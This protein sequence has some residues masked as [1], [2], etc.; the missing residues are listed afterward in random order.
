MLGATR[1]NTIKYR[2]PIAQIVTDGESTFG[3]A[4]QPDDTIQKIDELSEKVNV[5]QAL[6]DDVQK[7]KTVAETTESDDQNEETADEKVAVTEEQEN[8]LPFGVYLCKGILLPRAKKP[9]V[10]GYYLK[11]NTSEQIQSLVFFD[12][13]EYTDTQKC[14]SG[15]MYSVNGVI[16]VFDGTT[17]KLLGL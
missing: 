7:V 16:Y 1:Y 14:Q 17:C 5:L 15:K 2:H 12:G 4:S 9:E 13:T 3:A 11:Q 8:Y 10:P 6:V